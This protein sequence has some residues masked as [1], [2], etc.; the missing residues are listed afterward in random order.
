MKFS[1]HYCG[2]VNTENQ[3]PAIDFH[4]NVD[5]AVSEDCQAFRMKPEEAKAAYLEIWLALTLPAGNA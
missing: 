1:P 5:D 4:Q 3:W 2:Y